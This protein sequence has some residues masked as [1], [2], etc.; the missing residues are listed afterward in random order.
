[1]LCLL[2]PGDGDR[3][4]GRRGGLGCGLWFQVQTSSLPGCVTL[5]NSM[6]ALSLFPSA[7]KEIIIE[8]VS[9]SYN[10]LSDVTHMKYLEQS[11]AQGKH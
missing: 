3:G 4:S 1:M 6:C 11:L 7:E 5:V 2:H 10:P 8:S 9:E